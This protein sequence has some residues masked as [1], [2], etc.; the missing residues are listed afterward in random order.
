MSNWRTCIPVNPIV[1]GSTNL[2]CI[3]NLTVVPH[4]SASAKIQVQYQNGT[5]SMEFVNIVQPEYAEWG[6]DDE[7]IFTKIAS[8]LGLGTL[9]A[10]PS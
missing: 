6:T 5:L 8:K 9:V 1:E 4:E 7:W 10:P 2:F 3:M